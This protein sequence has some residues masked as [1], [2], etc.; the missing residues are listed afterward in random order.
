MEQLARRPHR[1]GVHRPIVPRPLNTKVIESLLP[2]LREAIPPASRPD[3]GAEYDAEE[4]GNENEEEDGGRPG[5]EAVRVG[6]SAARGEVRGGGSGESGDGKEG[7]KWQPAEGQ[8][9]EEVAGVALRRAEHVVT[10]GGVGNPDGGEDDAEEGVDEVLVGDDVATCWSA[11][12]A[13]EP[14]F[15]AFLSSV[16]DGDEKV[17]EGDEKDAVDERRVS[18]TGGNRRERRSLTRRG[19]PREP[20][21]VQ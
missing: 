21:P 13:D 5:W 8:P 10:V 17:E 19:G 11:D 2:P 9:E 16:V 7:E 18:I 15:A 1:S 12:E 4:D 3:A 14:D 6:S 20:L